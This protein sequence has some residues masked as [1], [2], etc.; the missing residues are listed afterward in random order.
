MPICNNLRCIGFRP[1]NLYTVVTACNAIEIQRPAARNLRTQ[2]NTHTPARPEPSEIF[3][4]V[5]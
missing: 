4:G 3:G 1:Q 2:W 5:P